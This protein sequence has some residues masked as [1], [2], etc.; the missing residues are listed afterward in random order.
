MAEF[1][2]VKKG[3]IQAAVDAAIAA[4][5]NAANGIASLD[6]Q[7]KVPAA[8]S[9]V[10]SVAG[11]QGDVL[12]SV[13]DVVGA[14]STTDIRLSNART[15][16]AHKTT[17]QPG[18][19]DTLTG[20]TDASVDAANKDGTAA[21]PSMRTLGTGALQA[22]PG[23]DAR[24]KTIRDEGVALA[25]RAILD[26]LGDGVIVED[27]ST[28]GQTK[29]TISG[30]A[31]GAA[32]ETAAGVTEQATEAEVEAGTAGNLFATVARNKAYI[33]SREHAIAVR[34]P[35]RVPA[36]RVTISAFS[37]QLGGFGATRA[38]D[39]IDDISASPDPQGWL[40][41]SLQ[42]ISA[43]IGDYVEFVVGPMTWIML[44]DSITEGQYSHTNTPS[45]QNAPP[46]N[47]ANYDN[48]FSTYGFHLQEMQGRYILN[49]GI[50]GN[51]TAQ[52]LSRLAADVNKWFPDIC[53][54]M[55]G[56]NDI[57]TDVPM[58]TIQGNLNSI[59]NSL[60]A[61]GTLPVLCTI[62][63]IINSTASGKQP[64]I[65]TLN[66]WIRGRAQTENWP[67]A[68][69]YAALSDPANPGKVRAGDYHESVHP[70]EQGY[71][72]LATAFEP[73]MDRIPRAPQLVALGVSSGQRPATPIPEY[74]KA[75]AYRI[76]HEAKTGNSHLGD[77][78]NRAWDHSVGPNKWID[79]IDIPRGYRNSPTLAKIRVVLQAF[80]V[81]GTTSG[82]AGFGEVRVYVQ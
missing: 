38:V 80:P 22:A 20:L 75:S 58:A 46:N 4:Q 41:R 79:H 31:A 44:G 37:S 2:V 17:H 53:S 51:T 71:S 18:G 50:G 26:F 39:S 11:R 30:A 47:Y 27:D 43:S 6:A 64:A 48:P 78:T 49:A 14:V 32:T 63:P 60:V 40:S 59:Y 54:V 81:A 1:I 21:T 61:N 62:P 36:S 72:R 57:I 68:D 82:L 52:M 65:D 7:S 76:S 25:N 34:R 12:L 69:A 35:Y 70:T 15:P 77:K 42:A 13:V 8:N 24:L 19:T 23:N 66:T 5:K 74:I 9:R 73:V 3:G 29:V 28:T 55:G 16:T 56:T 10:A 45:S 33:D 67:L